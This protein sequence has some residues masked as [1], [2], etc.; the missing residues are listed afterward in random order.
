MPDVPVAPAEEKPKRAPTLYIIAAIKLGKGLL[1]VLAAMGIFALAGKDLSAAFDS[2]LRWIHLDPERKFFVSIGE[3]LDT[4]TPANIKFIASST[5]LFGGFLIIIGLGLALR[6]RWAIWL[7]IGESAFFIPI[8]IYE[9]VRRHTPESDAHRM[10]THP[11][12]A[13]A[14]LLAVNV[15]VVAYLFQNRERLF[16][17]HRH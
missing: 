10:F 17:H 9:L 12:L 14:V 7:G 16:R 3:W 2:L 13:L 4:I 11:K 5:M 1:L 6:F 15:I 8:E